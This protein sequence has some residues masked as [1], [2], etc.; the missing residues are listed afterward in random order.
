MND[1]A[2]LIPELENSIAI[3]ETSFKKEPIPIP[4]I[5]YRIA[6]LRMERALR[7]S[8]GFVDGD[9]FPLEH[10]FAHGMYIRQIFV[11]AGYLVLTYIHKQSHPA[12]LLQGDVTVIEENGNRRIQAPK[13]FVTTAGTQRLCFCHTDTIWTTVHLNLANEKDIDK[14]EKEIY[15]VHYN[16]LYI[17]TKKGELEFMDKDKEA[18]K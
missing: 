13:S 12:F 3:K 9:F 10:T 14:I 4:N 7:K 17:E 11:P 16:E 2:V 1:L 5:D 8:E 15:A 6:L 18:V